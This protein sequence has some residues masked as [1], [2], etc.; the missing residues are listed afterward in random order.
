M[1]SQHHESQH[2][3]SQLSNNYQVTSELSQHQ[4]Q[5][6]SFSVQSGTFEGAGGLQQ[7]Q[8]TMEVMEDG[9]FPV[10]PVVPSGYPAHALP[11]NIGTMRFPVFATSSVCSEPSDLDSQ[12]IRP[13]NELP[14]DQFTFNPVVANQQY[15]FYQNGEQQYFSQP[16]QTYQSSSQV[17]FQQNGTSQMIN[18]NQVYEGTPQGLV[19][20]P[21]FQYQQSSVNV[22]TFR[23][24]VEMNPRFPCPPRHQY[25]PVTPNVFPV[26]VEP[27]CQNIIR[28]QQPQQPQQ[29]TEGWQHHYQHQPKPAV[30]QDFAASQNAS[31]GPDMLV[32]M[33][34]NNF[35]TGDIFQQQQVSYTES[36]ADLAPVENYQDSYN[37]SEKPKHLL[38]NS[39]GSV[40][41][42]EGTEV[43]GHGNLPAEVNQQHSALSDQSLQTFDEN[44]LN[45]QIN[46]ENVNK[47]IFQNKEMFKQI[48]YN[49]ECD[50]QTRSSSQTQQMSNPM[51]EV[52][53]LKSTQYDVIRSNPRFDGENNNIQ[54]Q[55]ILVKGT[56]DGTNPAFQN[57]LMPQGMRMVPQMPQS[58]SQHLMVAPDPP[59][60]MRHPS[61]PSLPGC[62][63]PPPPVSLQRFIRPPASQPGLVPVRCPPPPP[64][65]APP[66]APSVS[67]TAS[68]SHEEGRSSVQSQPGS[69]PLLV[70]ADKVSVPW[71]WKR[72]FMG[73]QVVYFR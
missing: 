23:S 61:H 52:P 51:A 28:P 3:E 44:A 55:P 8:A 21:D 73:E 10:G 9:R 50:D 11:G 26:G 36:Q 14:G 37:S 15:P 53:V 38:Q 18:S 69:L 31:F 43:P 49:Q 60:M 19:Q 6:G 22:P 68:L 39:P 64:P 35:A 70:Q 63:T 16:C 54:Q 27:H 13:N 25:T 56:R 4:Q 20:S 1:S 33:P 45:S 66:A 48:V 12:Q 62:P 71:G 17:H 34:E 40:F 67:Y 59:L 5:Y 58:V 29:Q 7:G 24:G 42:S 30:M 46:S 2:N 41:S 57:A 65:P 47:G 32:R 72:V